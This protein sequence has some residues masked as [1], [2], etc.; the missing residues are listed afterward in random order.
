M[1][2]GKNNTGGKMEEIFWGFCC[3]KYFEIFLY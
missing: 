1:R 3:Q 2:E